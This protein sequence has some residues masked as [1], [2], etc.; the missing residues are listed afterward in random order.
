MSKRTSRIRSIAIAALTAAAAV[1]MT[2][3]TAFADGGGVP[4]PK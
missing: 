3:G 4:F 2:V 1:L